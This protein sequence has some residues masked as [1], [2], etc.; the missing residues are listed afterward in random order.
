MHAAVL[1]AGGLIL[2][3]LCNLGGLPRMTRVGFFPLPIDSDGA[4]ELAVAVD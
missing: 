1:G 2:E 4:P 3:N